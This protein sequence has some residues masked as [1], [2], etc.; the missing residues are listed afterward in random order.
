MNIDKKA[1]QKEKNRFTRSTK[2]AAETNV[3]KSA[4]TDNVLRENRIIDWEKCKVVAKE[5]DRF[6]RWIRE[7]IKKTG[8]KAMNRDIGT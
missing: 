7:V 5:S 4:I 1:E 8:Y 6:T 2:Q 3:N